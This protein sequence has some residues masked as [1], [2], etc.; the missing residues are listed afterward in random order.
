VCLFS[1]SFFSKQKNKQDDYDEIEFV[2]SLREGIFETFTGTI[3][4]LRM[5][6]KAPLFEP[7]GE[8]LIS[9]IEEIWDDP[10]RNE[11]AT[12]GAIGV[13]G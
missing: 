9:F 10:N 7:Y 3:Q 13:L 4:G 5:D 6:N 2:N 8:L 11:G 1:F 12:R